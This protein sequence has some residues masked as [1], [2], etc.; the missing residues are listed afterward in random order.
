MKV[1]FIQNLWFEC[2]GV[3]YLSSSLKAHG[4]DCDVIIGSNTDELIEATGSR[5][6]DIIAF[7]VMTGMHIWATKLA[8]ELKKQYS[9][10]I[11]FGGPHPTFFPEIILE[12]GVDIVCRGEGEGALL[13]LVE[14]ISAKRNIRDIANLWIKTECGEIVRNELRHLEQ[15]LDQLP[16]PD[17]NLY[18]P[19]SGLCDNRVLLLT[20]SR[21]CPYNCTFCFNH[22]LAELYRGKGCFV[23]HRTPG[24]VIDEIARYIDERHITRVYFVDDTFTLNHAWLEEFLPLYGARFHGLSFHCLIRINQIN[25]KI[26]ALLRNNGCESVFFGVESGDEEI[27]NTVLGKAITDDD[28][29]RG[30]VLLKKHGITFRTYNIVGFPGETFDQALKTVKLNIEIGTDYP[31]CSIFMPYPGTR[32]AEYASERGYLGDLTVDS[33]ENSFH[34]TSLLNNPDRVRLINLHKFFQTVVLVPAL[35]PIVTL[36]VRLPVNRIFQAWFNLIYFCMI[37]RSEGRGLWQTIGI[38]LKNR[39]FFKYTHRLVSE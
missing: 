29:R 25:D 9:C 31:W 22:Q 17:H 30:A 3:M 15:N 35:L 27:R 5:T 16:Y 1:L 7:S 4:H 38:S 26:V 18:A 33:I 19:Y 32:L 20:A 2:L 12:N 11:V 8:A 36:L 37:V 39:A 6:P 23:R 28:I 24:S 34:R 14:A 10:P 13:D 21:G